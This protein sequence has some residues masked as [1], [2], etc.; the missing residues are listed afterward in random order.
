MQTYLDGQLNALGDATR[1]AILAK[2]I[3]GPISVGELAEKFTVSRPAI[4]QHLRIL[5][6]AKLVLDRADGNR[7]I[8]ELNPEGFASL[9]EYFDQ[10]WTT[11]LRAFKQRVEQLAAKEKHEH[12][13]KRRR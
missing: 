6:H 7:R 13:D 2:L 9:R 5:K 3:T 4:S 11:A 12:H 1:R 8:Y 10:F